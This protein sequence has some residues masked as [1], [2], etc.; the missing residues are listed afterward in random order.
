MKCLTCANLD[1]QTFKKHSAT[2]F[3]KCKHEEVGMFVNITR[4]RTCKRFTQAE[5]KT[6][7]SR[8]EWADKAF[9]KGA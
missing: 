6:I 4:E 8:Q 1:L 7:T 2:G 5:G 9:G 3:G